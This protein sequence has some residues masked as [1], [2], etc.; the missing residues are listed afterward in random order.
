MVVVVLAGLY[1]LGLGAA[2]L[3][4]PDITRRFLL[5]FA[6]SFRVHCIEML[7]RL[8]VGGALIV[9]SPRMLFSAAFSIFG[10]ILAVTACV[11]LLLPWRWHHRFAQR[12][13]PAVTR[14]MALVGLVSLVL[15]GVMLVAVFSGWS[16]R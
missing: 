16:V 2:C 8:A 14:A 6:G 4:L 1:F 15:G 5:G 3:V 9:L 7:L 13:V 12:T 11:L 10:W